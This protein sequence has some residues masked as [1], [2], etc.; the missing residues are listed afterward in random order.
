MCTLRLSYLMAIVPIS[1]LLTVSFFVLFTLRK[2]EEKGLRAFGYTV[3]SLLWLAALVIFS[4][5]VYKT[6]QESFPR[7]NTMSKEMMCRDGMQ[8]DMMQKKMKMDYMPQS[9]EKKDAAGK[10]LPGQDEKDPKM[11][12]C[13]TNKGII[14]KN[15]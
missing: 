11:S 3:A 7:K 5:A 4:G 1:V 6:A 14:F 13:Q 2:I 8:K 15:E 9:M 10:F 12:K